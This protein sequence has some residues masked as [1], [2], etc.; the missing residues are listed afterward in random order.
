MVA[1]DEGDVW[2]G[3]DSRH[4]HPLSIW[5]S[6]TMLSFETFLLSTY[7]PTWMREQKEMGILHDIQADLLRDNS[8]IAPILLKFRLLAAKLGSHPLQE[9]VKHEI[10]G[11]PDGV[12]VP[13]YR[14]LQVGYKGHFSGP[15]GSGIKNA[16]IPNY[17]I[18]KYAGKQWSEYELRQSIAVVDQLISSDKDGTGTLSL[19]AADLILILQ[20]KVYENYACNSVEGTMSVASLKEVQYVV[21]NRILEMTIELQKSVPAAGEITIA[22][23]SM[24]E[25]SPESGK[26]NQIFNQT[27]HGN[28]TNIANTGKVGAINA[29]VTKGDSAALERSLRAAGIA[30]TDAKEF[31]EILQSEEPESAQE[32]FG[33]R[34]KAWIAKSLGKAV[35]GTWT[36]GLSVATEVLKK[37]AL[38]YYGLSE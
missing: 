11:Y 15:F 14:K 2:E 28:M 5:G 31:S 34:A 20:G 21:R 35:D 13:E 17:L 25:K 16:P 36:A 32:P 23:K 38:G 1:D 4:I 30:E 18:E 27:I 10:E 37:A 7:N 29:N 33:K 6:L 12:D 8:D 22:V 3:L 9:W 26:V 19:N 24:D